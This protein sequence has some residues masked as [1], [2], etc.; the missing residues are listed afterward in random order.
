[1][2]EQALKLD[3]LWR[4][5][6][7]RDLLL[8][9][10]AALADA[11]VRQSAALEAQQ[12]QLA[13]AEAT[14]AAVKDE[15]RAVQR[16]LDTYVR[17]R[18]RARE[19]IETGRAPDYHAAAAQLEQCA[20]VVD[21]EETKLLELFERLEAAT[22]ARDGARGGL[23]LIQGRLAEAQARQAARAEGLAAELQAATAHR[24]AQ[25]DGIER[26]HMA[27]Y[28]ELRRRG[29]SPIAPVR[30]GACTGCSM[31]VPSL[32]LAEHRRGIAL[33]TCRSCGRFL[34]ELL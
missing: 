25:R 10:R 31:R 4:A 9:E 28:D 26:E 12:Q 2:H 6:Q 16:K 24:D 30:D 29:T 20:R 15:E 17:H 22:A 5:D 21:E 1:M 11:I 33:R 3:S 27:R 34:G 14:L 18:D 32:E 7:A 19:L 8:R 13:Q 23:A